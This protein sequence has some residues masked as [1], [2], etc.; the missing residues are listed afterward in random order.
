VAWQVFDQQTFHLLRDEY[1]IREVSK[2]TAPTIE[3]LADA[4]DG[5][6]ARAF[7]QTV[8]RFND[9]VRRD[10]PFNPNVLDGRGTE[11]IEPPKS[12]WAMPIEQGP[13]TAYNVTCGITFTFGGVRT[14][15]SSRVIDGDGRPVCGLYA[16]GEMLGGLFYLNYPGGSGLTAGSVFGRTAGVNAA[17]TARQ[18]RICHT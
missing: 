18:E 15:T 8:A 17:S 3:K 4:I 12:N 6:D 7:V 14:D 9:A 5:I 13:F 16:C 10:I 11:G 1:R 2:V